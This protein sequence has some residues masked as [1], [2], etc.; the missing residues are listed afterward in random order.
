MQ[1]SKL[2]NLLAQSVLLFALIS[3]AT[4]K[5]IYV[6]AGATGANNG[7]TWANAYKHLQ[8]ALA[9]AKA[10]TKPVE[11]RVAQGVYRPDENTLHPDGTGDRAATFQLI[12]GVTI[13]GGYAGFGEPDPNARDIDF[14]ETVLSG[15]LVGNDVDVKDPCGLWKEPTRFDNS[16]HVVSAIETDATPVLDGFT[17]TSGN[18][19]GSDPHY[20]LGGG[21]FIQYSSPTVI[22]CTVIGNSSDYRGGGI[23]SSD[24]DN[25]TI[26]NCAIKKNG[27]KFD[28]GGIDCSDCNNYVIKNCIITCNKS[29]TSHETGKGGGGICCSN[30]S[31]RNQAS[32]R[33]SNCIVSKN[34]TTGAGA[35]MAFDYCVPNISNCSITEN[36]G[37]E[38]CEFFEC[39]AELRNSIISDNIG[40]GISCGQGS[41][42]IEDCMIIRNQDIGIL[43]VIDSTLTMS[44]CIIS[45]N[46][47][48]KG[49]GLY[50]GRSKMTIRGC[51]IIYNSAKYGGGLYFQGDNV[52]LENCILWKNTASLGPQVYMADISSG[53]T[54]VRGTN[55]TVSYSDVFGSEDEIFNDPCSILNWGDGNIEAE[56]C[57][58]NSN[59]GD[60]HL[61]S[62]GGRWD[63][64]SASWVKDDVT[65][66]CIDAGDPASPIGLEPFPNGGIINMGG[67]GGTAEASK[68]YFGK[69]P[70]E[71][72]VAGDINGD[73]IINFRDFAIMAFH[74]LEEY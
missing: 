35:G 4:G 28:G 48:E 41:L 73:C 44:N 62:Q 60:H 19:N 9:D 5:I 69:P 32:F 23:Y 39:S 1:T 34:S 8:D 3:V 27:T 43:C 14:Y 38:S 20:Y 46:M 66:L 72:I 42:T 55:L 71:T 74:W 65:S 63:A 53:P 26:D 2:I 13:N 36:L 6:D 10:A 25:F 51:S 56:P 54:G 22:N 68:S 30:W 31:R 47:A 12:N 59:N 52:K 33:I 67:Y 18:G 17:I 21:M 40:R 57:F 49:G 45:D 11:I 64:N 50:G 16:Y 15:D 24:S 70:C 29:G 7:T 37:Y 61:K 58:A